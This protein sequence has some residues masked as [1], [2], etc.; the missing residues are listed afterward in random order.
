MRV[1]EEREEDE[2]Q[3]GPST[4]QAAYNPDSQD[5]EDTDSEEGYVRNET[6]VIK[7]TYAQGQN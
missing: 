1:K 3:P 4:S 2:E 6:P 7:T 5:S